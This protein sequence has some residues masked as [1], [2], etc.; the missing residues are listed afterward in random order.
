MSLSTPG[1]SIPQ[2]AKSP[3]L[4][5]GTQVAGEQ[6]SRVAFQEEVSFIAPLLSGHHSVALGIFSLTSPSWLKKYFNQIFP[7]NAFWKHEVNVICSQL[8]VWFL[9]PRGHWQ[10][11]EPFLVVTT[12]G[13]CYWLQWIETGAAAQQPTMHRTSAITNNNPVLNFSRG[14]GWKTTGWIS[15]NLVYDPYTV[16]LK[17]ICY[18]FVEG[19]CIYVHQVY[20]PVISFWCVMSLVSLSG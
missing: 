2:C 20:R 12:S 10:C 15:L 18:S 7:K 13:E 6:A 5:E 9:P 11:L 4:G 17:S 1:T 8:R 3:T 19:F 14:K 16:L